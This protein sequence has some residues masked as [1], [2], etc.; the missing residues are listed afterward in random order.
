MLK[1][2]KS[3][4][5]ALLV[6]GAL[7][8]SLFGTNGALAQ[9]Q[10]RAA[11]IYWQL[12]NANNS[13]FRYGAVAVPTQPQPRTVQ[14]PITNT[15]SRTNRHM[16]QN[17]APNYKAI[18]SSSPEPMDSKKSGEPLWGVVSEVRGGILS[19]DVIF[20]DRHDLRWPNPFRN[21]RESGVDFNGE[22][23]FT[24]P[25][26]LDILF[27]PRPHIGFMA[28]SAGDTSSAYAGATWDGQ[29]DSGIFLEG[30]L[31]MAIHN[32]KRRNGNPDRIEFGS[33]ALFRLGGE[34]GWR[35]N[36]T[37]GISLIWDHMSNAGLISSKNQGIDNIGI[38]YGYRFSN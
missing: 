28:N 27:A 18:A 35:Y 5:Q 21:D 17:S 14:Q 3:A 9:Q 20:P 7:S 34:V 8:I 22:V 36:D 30:F 23:L 12:M 1:L 25:A 31:G 26:F 33:R 6:A 29:W 13:Q 38:R 24:S 11:D 37:H 32:G 4:T 10:S 16:T 19:H 15:Q 2:Y